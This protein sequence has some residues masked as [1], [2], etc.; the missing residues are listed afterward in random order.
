MRERAESLNAQLN[1]DSLPERG[2][3]ITVE[4]KL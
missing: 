2:T 4:V 1:I 3:R